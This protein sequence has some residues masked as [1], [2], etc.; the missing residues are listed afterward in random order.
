V[1][2]RR[3]IEDKHAEVPASCAPPRADG[4]IGQH[5]DLRVRQL[6][7][8][9]RLPQLNPVSARLL[10]LLPDASALQPT[11]LELGC[12]SG[13]LLAALLVDGATHATGV[14]LSPGSI[15]AARRRA[16]E[17]GWI[18]RAAFTVGD[19]AAL[20][21]EQH[22]WVVLDRAICCYSD[23]D[24]LLGNSISAAAHRYAFS[25]PESRGLRGL[26]NRLW[27]PV[28]NAIDWIRGFRCRGHVHDVRVIEARLAAAGFRRLRAGRR[29]LWYAAVF[30]R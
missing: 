30:E 5:F 3:A 28:D 17:G 26:I 2:D 1:S 12:G 16:A 23:L 14:D 22:D 4:R 27:W 7:S 19:A 6:M 11:V 15:E 10:A 13:A 8:G 9:G 25:V 18:D 29:R 24:R 20:P 21:L